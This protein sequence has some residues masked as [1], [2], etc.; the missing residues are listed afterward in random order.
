MDTISGGPLDDNLIPYLTTRRWVRDQYL[1]WWH[2]DEASSPSW[3]SR[4][5]GEFPSQASNALFKL[6]WL[7]RSKERHLKQPTVDSGGKLV[8][9]I[10]V[11]GGAAE[12]VV[13]LCELSGG[14]KILRYGAWRAAD[15]LDL[16][17]RFLDPVIK[18][19]TTVR[20]DAIGIGYNF[21]LYLRKKGFPIELVNVGLPCEAKPHWHEN[22]PAERFT[23]QKARYYQNLADAFENDEI[24]GL[25]D[26][27]TIGQLAGLLSEIDSRGRI[28]IESKEDAQKRGVP[29]PDRADAL[30]LALGELPPSYEYR[31]GREIDP[32]LTKKAFVMPRNDGYAGDRCLAQDAFDDLPERVKQGITGHGFRRGYIW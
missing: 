12:T 25:A 26:D 22:N 1:A 13:Y 21:G 14:K 19:L 20:V 7:E 17:A 29:S 2:G 8:A 16:V 4:V 11:G 28:K 18:R 23:N 5:R 3:M 24:D 10:D 15:T 31:S 9:G 30:M 6:R 32:Q 27:A